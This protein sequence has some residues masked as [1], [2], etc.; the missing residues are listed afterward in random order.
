MLG[1]SHARS[2][3]MAGNQGRFSL[4]FICSISLSLSLSLSFS[5]SSLSLSLS[6]SLTHTHTHTRTQ[7]HVCTHN[8][9]WLR[10]SLPDSVLPGSLYTSGFPCVKRNMLTFPSSLV[11]C[12]GNIQASRTLGIGPAHPPWCRGGKERWRVTKKEWK[13]R[14]GEKEADWWDMS[15]SR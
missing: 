4:N 5:L 15:G 2:Y 8:D 1:E 6:L 11:C 7:V 14:M 13:K 10:R 12:H 9:W 3:H